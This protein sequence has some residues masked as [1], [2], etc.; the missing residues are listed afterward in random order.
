ML[1]ETGQLPAAADVVVVGAGI[2]GHCAALAAAERGASVLLLEK[3]SQAGGSSAM[4]GGGFI[5]V[6]TD[7]MVADGRHDTPEELRAILL[8]YGKN[9]NNPELVDLFVGRQLEAYELLKKHGAKFTL[10]ALDPRLHMTGTGRVVTNLH[11]AVQ[12]DPDITFVSKTAGIKLLRDPVSSRVQRVIVAF[13]DEITEVE[14][15][16][17]VVLTTGGFS[18]SRELLGIFAP[19]LLDAVKHG[20]VANTGDGLIMAGDLGAGFADLG[21]VSGSFGGAIRNYPRGV[22]GADEVPPLLFSFIAGGIL[23]NVEGRR[24]VNEGQNYKALGGVGMQQTGGVAFQVFD[25]KLM[26]TALD[27]SSVNNYA[28][29]I[30]GGYIRKANTVTELAAAMQIDGATL[31]L[32]IAR[33]N[34]NVAN[35]IDP[36]FGR[37]SALMP[38]DTPPYYIAASA[39]A[40]TS[41]YGGITANRDMAVLDWTGQPIEGLYAAG[42]VVGGLH[43]AGYYSGM[44]L[45]SSATFGMVAGQSAATTVRNLQ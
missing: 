2:A 10:S 22:Q 7:L 37:E 32:T 30:V 25:S 20:G 28:E 35:G 21:Y 29:G 39:N 4:A 44:S 24:F 11:M 31:E 38:V 18:R 27:D 43:G 13:G 34:E 45:S 3:A 42:E 8:K 15:H 1:R 23:V 26:N 14:A 19:E 6:G 12:S 17:G 33:Y 9:R 5:F 41:T 40:I 16:S 36:D